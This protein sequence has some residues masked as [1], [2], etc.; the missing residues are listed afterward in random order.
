M[1]RRWTEPGDDL[2][3]PIGDQSSVRIVAAA[4]LN[5]S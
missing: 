3:P 4:Q 5:A 1:S 2:E